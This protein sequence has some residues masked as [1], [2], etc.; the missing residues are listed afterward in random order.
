MTTR[1]LLIR[2]ATTDYVGRALAGRLPGI[3]LNEQGRREAAQLAEQCAQAEL[4]AIYASPLERAQE[5]AAA[6]AG[7]RQLELQTEPDLLELD[8]GE[9]T[10]RRFDDLERDPAWKEFNAFRSTLGIPGGETLL[11]VQLRAVC[12][13]ERIRQR[14]AGQTVAVVSHADTLRA[15]MTHYLGIPL[16]L[17][18][19]IDIAPATVSA[20]ELASWG[21]RLLCLNAPGWKG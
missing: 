8:Y 7:P 5:T 9:W 17:G 3:S 12:V 1:L 15:A 10:N 6:L 4:A 2:H 14:H 19:R 13:L 16:D 11:A 18:L 20:I 21:P